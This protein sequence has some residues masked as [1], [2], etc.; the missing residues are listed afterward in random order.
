MRCTHALSLVALIVH[1]SL[2]LA[3]GLRAQEEGAGPTVEKPEPTEPTA[4]RLVREKTIYVP[5]AKL[6][7]VFEKEGRGIFLP[8]EEF[9][10]LWSRTQPAPPVRPPD[11]PPADAVIRGGRYSGTVNGGIARFEVNYQIEAL[12]DEWSTLP[13]EF[14]NVAVESVQLSDPSALFSFEK[15]GYRLFLPAKGKYEVRLTFSVRVSSSPGKKELSFGIPPVGVSHLTLTI[16][17]EDVRVKV[18]PEMA[19]ALTS[20]VEGGTR[21]SAFVGNASQV[22]ISWTPPAGKVA[23][24]GAV[25]FA[26]QYLRGYLGER[27]V[28]LQSELRYEV[29][30]GEVDTFRVRTPDGM[31]LLKVEGENLREWEEKDGVLIVQLHSPVKGSYALKLRFERILDQ[32]PDSLTLPLPVALG[33]RRESGWLALSHDSTLKVRVSS[34]TG[35]SQLDPEEVPEELRS[36]LRAGFRYL[37]PPPPLGL[38]VEAI[39]PVV[40]SQTTSVISLAEEEDTWVGLVDYTIAKA[41]LFTLEM[42]VPARWSVVEVG[43]PE[44][45]EDFQVAAVEG[46]LKAI[47]VNLKNRALGQF[48]LSFKLSAEGSASATESTLR[49][50]RVT[51]TE[52]DRGVLGI[53]APHSIDLKTL[54][55]SGVRSADVQELYRAGVMGLVSSDAGTPLTYSYRDNAQQPASVKVG[56]TTKKEEVKV[57]VATLIETADDKVTFTYYLDYTVRYR[58][59]D[60]LSFRTPEALDENSLKIQGT[61]LKEIRTGEPVEGRRLWEI[62]LQ[63]AQPGVYEFTGVYEMKLGALEAGKARPETAPLLRPESVDTE[64]AFVAIRRTGTLE[65][66][67]RETDMEIIDISQ[68][69]DKLRRGKIHTALRQLAGSPELTL[70]LTRYNYE[71][72]KTTVVNRIHLRSLLSEKP[73][74]LTTRATILVRNVDAA[75]LE[76][77]LPDGARTLGLYVNGRPESLK[78]RQQDESDDSYLAPIP[79]APDGA[80]IPLVVVYEQELAG[81]EEMGTLGRLSLASLEVRGDVPVQRVELD[82]LVP[83][84]YT[85]MNW[86]GNLRLRAGPGRPPPEMKA[87]DRYTL[88]GPNLTHFAFASFAP[89]AELDVYYA[90]PGIFEFLHALAFALV[91][92]AGLLLPL[93]LGYPKLWASVVAVAAPLVL[94]WFFDDPV[95]GLFV[96][97]TVAGALVALFFAGERFL[98]GFRAWRASRLALAPDP[99]LENAG[100]PPPSEVPPKSES[101]EARKA[102]DPGPDET[103]GSDDAGAEPGGRAS[104]EKRPSRKKR[105]KKTEGTDESGES[106]PE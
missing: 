6:D 60:S 84:D 79:P 92:A 102:P 52:Q 63:S 91:L 71:K 41:G 97:A 89:T 28:R 11:K 51:G 48:Q 86:S 104:R 90:T 65:V 93:K 26:E 18:E 78:R 22:K 61:Q 77:G 37:A 82:L 62:V 57:D 38:Q 74:K 85:Y 68:L 94:T 17:E 15:A 99:F 21:L 45:V 10:R 24:G 39:T 50:P 54:E 44:T 101:K 58:G 32:T 1:V 16:P 30:R 8:Y 25:L 29:E 40:R 34:S 106:P 59:V 14:S 7:D 98:G 23:E 35:F 27:I 36:Q 103:A 72:L 42:R 19:A 80:V 13:L 83:E 81:K 5:F 43:N 70:V 105:P 55:V 56:L 66:Q 96:T 95:S 46:D 2:F 64:N 73:C 12:K 31:G 53:A 49:P 9:L 100:R 47:T 88:T 33:V 67:P 4:S 3:P 76:L 75:Y 87:P 20:P 69:P